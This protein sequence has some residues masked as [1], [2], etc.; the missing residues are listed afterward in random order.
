MSDLE[1]KV[2]NW[3]RGAFRLWVL[4]S[5]LWS[6]AV[7][8]GTVAIFGNGLPWSISNLVYWKSP[9]TSKLWDFPADWDM[10][11]IQHAVTEF[12]FSTDLAECQVFTD[13]RSLNVGTFPVPP[14]MTQHEIEEYERKEGFEIAP[15]STIPVKEF[16]ELMREEKVKAS[17]PDECIIRLP[18]EKDLH[19][20]KPIP[21]YAI[22]LL[23]GTAMIAPPLGL[24]A[25]SAVLFW[26]IAGFRKPS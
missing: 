12:K 6:F 10:A 22:A 11:T 25:I 5:L 3:R 4:F 13:W 19:Q 15:A 18:E 9:I 14:P 2:I 26:V 20:Q 21:L 23:T 24:F 1:K 7:L 8:V 16:M 17:S